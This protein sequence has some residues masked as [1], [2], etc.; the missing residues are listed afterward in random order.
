[1]LRHRPGLL[2]I[3]SAIRHGGKMKA[4]EKASVTLPRQGTNKSKISS[5]IRF[6]YYY[7]DYL[8]GQV[9][10]YFRYILR[11]KV[12]IY[13][14]Y[15]YDFINDAKRSNIVLKS[16]VMKWLFAFIYKPDYNF[17]LYNDPDVILSRKEEMT[18]EEIIQLNSKYADLFT[19]L[20]S[21]QN[22][23]YLQ[24]KNDSKEQTLATIL[25]TIVKVA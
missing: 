9:V 16:G 6:S 2:P 20:S 13:D 10:V 19:E 14:R 21:R 18:E 25:Q 24:I 17:Y 15:Y 22:G 12:V 11:G 7:L 8:L 4:E 3:L 23:T 5:A 1:M